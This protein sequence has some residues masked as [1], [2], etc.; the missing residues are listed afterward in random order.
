M[1]T[2]AVNRDGGLCLRR[3]PSLCIVFAQL[4]SSKRRERVPP[5]GGSKPRAPPSLRLRRLFFISPLSDPSAATSILKK[6]KRAR[7]GNVTFDQVKVFFFPRC[8]GFTSV[9]SRGGCTLGMMQRHTVL[10]TYTM[11][12]FAAEQ[13]LL[14]REKLLNRLRE[15][16]LEALKLKVRPS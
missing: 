7:R 4:E 9:P 14:R 10:R 3:P 11:A 13:R 6:S 12:E 5:G 8:Q 16:K 2:G 1:K 15:E